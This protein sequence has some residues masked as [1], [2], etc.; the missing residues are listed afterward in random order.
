MSARKI[1]NKIIQ[2]TQNYKLNLNS[3]RTNCSLDNQVSECQQNR[4]SQTQD[5]YFQTHTHSGLENNIVKQEVDK[6]E[7]QNLKYFAP[8]VLQ[9][10]LGIH[11]SLEG[12][13]LGVE[14]N[15]SRCL[16][17][18]LAVIVHKWAEGLVL[19]LVLKKSNMKI[20]KASI[21]ITIQASMNPIGIATGWILSDAGN[22]VSVILMSISVGTF[23]YI[24]TQEVIAEAKQDI[25]LLNLCFIYLVLGLQVLFILFKK[26]QKN[27]I[28]NNTHL[29]FKEHHKI[30]NFKIKCE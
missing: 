9:L 22:L 11:A 8:F 2:S 6:Q 12:L 21:V 25:K 30:F 3:Q 20:K 23:I 27:Q 7:S 24:S 29:N 17:I 26:Q 19:G 10:T 1:L 13:A 18:A 16:T 5:D 4:Y 28:N 15:F 14:Q